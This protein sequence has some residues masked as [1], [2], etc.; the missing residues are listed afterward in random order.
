MLWQHQFCCAG[1]DKQSF[2]NVSMKMGQF[3]ALLHCQLVF[4]T[5][6]K[7]SM[8][9]CLLVVTICP[10]WEFNHLYQSLAVILARLF[11]AQLLPQTMFA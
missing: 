6:I 10:G 8:F 2:G 5:A 9:S 1:R 7:Q 11:V 3:R 4:K